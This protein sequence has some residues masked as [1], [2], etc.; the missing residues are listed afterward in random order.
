MNKAFDAFFEEMRDATTCWN[1]I[2]RTKTASAK[3]VRD[4]ISRLPYSVDRYVSIGVVTFPGSEERIPYR[5]IILQLRRFFPNENIML[6]QKDISILLSQEKQSFTP[7]LANVDIEQLSAMLI[8]YDGILGVSDKTRRVDFLPT[9]YLLARKTAFI[10]FNLH[11][12]L[13]QSR[14]VFF[15]D[16]GMYCIIDMAAKQYLRNPINTDVAY[17][18]HPAVIKLTRYD[19]QHGTDLRNTLYYYLTQDRNLVKSSAVAHVHRNTVLNKINKITKL[20]D[21]NLDNP[22]LRQKLILSCQ[23]ILYAERVMNQS[24]VDEG[25]YASE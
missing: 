2:M 11:D 16:Y 15:Q 1:R 19:A 9:L 4:I 5:E 3:E 23:L 13:S 17:L 21:L 6:Y 12:T 24:F 20:I 14:I 18:I 25:I 10:A 8:R 7:N 22:R